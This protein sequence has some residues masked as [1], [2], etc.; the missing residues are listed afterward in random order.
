MQVKRDQLSDTKVKLT[1]TA[2]QA[3]INVVKQEALE[4]LSINV[5]VQGFR[6]GKAPA[7]L[8]EKQV[9]QSSLQS[10]FLETAVNQL[11]VQAAQQE[12]LRPVAPPDIAISKFVP[13]TTLE[14]TAE[15]ETVG[16]I[17]LPDYKKIKLAPKVT[18]VTS[19]DV[20]TVIENILS[21]GGEKK[22]VKRA[23]KDKDEVVIDFFGT[24]TKTKEP[25]NGADGKD[26]PLVLGSKSFI[27]GFEDELIGAKSDSDI[28]FEITFPADYSTKDLRSK[29]VSF[30]VKVKTVS[31]I[32]KPK[33]DDT[34]AA[35]LGPFKTV[36]E[37][38][39]D[40]KRQLET[41]RD[42][43]NQRTYDNE[44]LEKIAAKSTVSIPG[45]MIE[46]EID[47][48]EEEEKRN[49][50]YRGQTWQEHLAEEGIDEKAHREKQREGATLR[51]KAGL[52]LAEVA[53]L[54]DINVMPEELEMRL[55]L[56]KGQ[57]TD[58]SMQAELDKPE[59]RRD[60]MSRMLTEKTLDTLRSYAKS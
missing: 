13:F 10:E 3:L 54:E 20:D 46:Q 34:F 56:L 17:K 24:D 1:I 53:E 5:N 40:V 6:P 27:P 16:T 37:L 50:V 18:P 21:R 22:E 23:A 59:N 47:R 29:K 36:A 51:V 30:A 26:Y 32:V 11:Y 41:E 60:I 15:V 58:L 9:D 19:K 44:L 8:V 33:L 14:F 25:I 57:Y 12:K 7:N 38:K 52:V 31:E 45:T 55:S 2:D 4:R 35:T 28:N 42:Q 48:M 39:A 43:E 49:I